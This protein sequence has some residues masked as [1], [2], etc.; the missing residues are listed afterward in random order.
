MEASG[1]PPS[2]CCKVADNL[3]LRNIKVAEHKPVHGTAENKT[4]ACLHKQNGIKTPIT[5]PASAKDA[6]AAYGRLSPAPTTRPKM[7]AWAYIRHVRQTMP[8]NP[9]RPRHQ[10]Q[11]SPKNAGDTVVRQRHVVNG[12]FD[13]DSQAEAQGIGSATTKGDAKQ[14]EE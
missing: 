13:F 7:A 2:Y 3:S 14:M 8:H 6:R 4:R 11:Q 10:R 5:A 1:I 9:Q 12:P